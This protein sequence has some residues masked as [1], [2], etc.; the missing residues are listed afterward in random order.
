MPPA[1]IWRNSTSSLCGGPINPPCTGDGKW[2]RD[3]VVGERLGF[4][5]SKAHPAMGNYHH[6]QN[7]SA[8]N[9]DLNVISTICNLYVADGLY[10][11]DSNVHSPL[12]GFAYDGFPIYGPYESEGLMAKDAINEQTLDACNG[13]TDSVRGYHYHVTPSVSHDQY[14][15]LPLVGVLV[16]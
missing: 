6:H 8:F 13:H 4:D 12:I 15:A 10:L 2:N 9:L 14:T 1:L 7:P 16:T 11:I 5:C 3:A